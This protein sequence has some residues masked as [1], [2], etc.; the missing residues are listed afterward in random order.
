VWWSAGKAYDRPAVDPAPTTG[1]DRRRWSLAAA[2][3][4]LAGGAILVAVVVVALASA[5]PRFAI[6]ATPPT[7]AIRE[8]D[9]SLYLQNCASCHGPQGQGT[10]AGPS[11]VGSGAAAADFYLRTGR[12]P[13]GAPD[14]RP[15]RQDPRFTDAERIALVQY[16]ASL[17]PG[18]DIPQVASGGDVHRGWELYTA[19]CAACHGA[20]GSG[21]AVGGGAAAAAL[22]HATGLDVAEAMLIGPGVMPPFAFARADQDAIVAYV[23]YLRGAPSPGGAEIGG[24]GPVSE[25]FVS[26]V[27][28][29]ILVILT[30]RFAGRRSDGAEAATEPTA[31]S[32]ADPVVG[33]KPDARR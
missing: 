11:L 27:V 23:Q 5:G 19:N 10:A 20:S 2:G 14:Q 18:P 13:L 30:V 29:L 25:G 31:G 15:V 6:A 16:V 33:S 17:G 3:G 7:G 32:P 8:V 28:G 22:G 12:M 21:N 4:W 1:D 9:A 24:F 26:I